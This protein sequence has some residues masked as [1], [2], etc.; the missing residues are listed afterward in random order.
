MVSSATAAG[1]LGPLVRA[2]RVGAHVVQSHV[3]FGSSRLALEENGF[4]VAALRAGMVFGARQSRVV[5]DLAHD[6]SQF[7]ES[8]L[9]VDLIS[10]IKQQTRRNECGLIQLTRLRA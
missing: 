8:R 5:D 2:L 1:L 10:K 6:T 7:A 9:G 4:L 3:L